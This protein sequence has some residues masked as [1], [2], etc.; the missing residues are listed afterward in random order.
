M[1]SRLQGLDYNSKARE[2]EHWSE[3]N[4]IRGRFNMGTGIEGTKIRCHFG[5]GPPT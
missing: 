2:A 5:L 1:R 3:L 4:L